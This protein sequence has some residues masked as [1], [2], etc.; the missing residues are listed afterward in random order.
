MRGR[1]CH[2]CLHL[3]TTVHFGQ[4]AS[5]GIAPVGNSAMCGVCQ[6]FV[7][8]LRHQLISEISSRAWQ[9]E[10]FTSWQ[11][12][13]DWRRGNATTWPTP[14]P[15]V[16]FALFVAITNASQFGGHQSGFQ[17]DHEVQ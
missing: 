14:L 1:A 17:G 7:T 15:G 4:F 5:H 8:N 9:L 16:R 13:Q 10:K 6:S 12:G 11:Y 2:W 3:Q